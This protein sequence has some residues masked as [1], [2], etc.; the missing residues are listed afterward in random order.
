M[1]LGPPTFPNG[2]LGR[3]GSTLPGLSKVSIESLPGGENTCGWEG[4]WGVAPYLVC[5]RDGGMYVERA[6]PTCTIAPI[7][8]VRETGPAYMNNSPNYLCMYAE[9]ARPTF[10][11]GNSV[12]T[13]NGPGLHTLLA[14]VY[15]R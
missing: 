4:A 6:R 12:C 1:C 7:I 15:V 14:I 2:T 3:F 10:T 9:R 13:R 11:I 8:C 5:S